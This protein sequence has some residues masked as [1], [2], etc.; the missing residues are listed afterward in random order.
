[1]A[2]TNTVHILSSGKVPFDIPYADKYKQTNKQIDVNTE[3]IQNE[4]L[5]LLTIWEILHIMNQTCPG[6]E[7]PL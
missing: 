2:I 4:T 6:S 5:R 7:L 1:M 3:Y